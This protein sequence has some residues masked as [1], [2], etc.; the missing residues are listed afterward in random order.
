M[1]DLTLWM[2][3]S[4]KAEILINNPGRFFHYEPLSTSFIRLWRD[5]SA[6]IQL[7]L[8]RKCFQKAIVLSISYH[9]LPFTK[10]YDHL[11]NGH[12][13]LL[14]HPHCLL[15]LFFQRCHLHVKGC[16][17]KLKTLLS[18]AFQSKGT[19]TRRI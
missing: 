6:K 13:N 19:T 8:K 11:R 1:G 3:L 17:V 14:R 15:H 16:P 2:K 9:P 18:M 5:L 12:F 7:Y 10:R 4:V